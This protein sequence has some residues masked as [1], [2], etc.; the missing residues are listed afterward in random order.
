MRIT[1]VARTL[2]P[3]LTHVLCGILKELTRPGNSRVH[4]LDLLV[5]H[6]HAST[7]FKTKVIVGVKK[8]FLG[9]IY[10]CRRRLLDRRVPLRAAAFTTLNLLSAVHN[11]PLI[12]VGRYEDV[13]VA[14]GIPDALQLG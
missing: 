10:P 12:I 8:R 4:P 13:F 7:G 2:S 3:I 11:S 9:H 1:S 5:V 6:F 14:D